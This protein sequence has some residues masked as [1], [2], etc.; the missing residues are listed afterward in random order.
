MKLYNFLDRRCDFGGN[1]DS[2]IEWK[3]IGHHR[4][5][6]NYKDCAVIGFIGTMS[7]NTVFFRTDNGAHGRTVGAD[8]FLRIGAAYKCFALGKEIHIPP[9]FAADCVFVGDIVVV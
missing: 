8:E 6:A 3:L 5:N 9:H 2:V 1:Q 7:I 4:L